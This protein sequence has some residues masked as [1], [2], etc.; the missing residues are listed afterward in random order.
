MAVARPAHQTVRP[1][2]DRLPVAVLGA[3]PDAE[4]VQRNL[5]CGVAA[6]E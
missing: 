6:A 1:Q 5:E 2:R 3:M 4:D